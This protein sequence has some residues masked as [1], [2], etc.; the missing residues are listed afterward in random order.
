MTRGV[1][2]TAFLRSRE[3]NGWIAILLFAAALS[4]VAAYGFYQSSL[5]SF[6]KSKSD[7]ET[8]AVGLIDAFVDNYSAVR[9]E[10]GGDGA[11][12]P[13]TFRVH[14]IERFNQAAGTARP[15]RLYWVGR[16]GK[17][18]AKAPIDAEMAV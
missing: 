2:I 3:G 18:V 6:V 4:F 14:S 5:R 17:E 12:V 7:E 10:F 16:E 8:T 11:P 15:L 9:R 1:A 13:A